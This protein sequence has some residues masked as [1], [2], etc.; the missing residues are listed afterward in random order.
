MFLDIDYHRFG[1]K[2]GDD[3]IEVFEASASDGLI[4]RDQSHMYDFIRAA[5]GYVLNVVCGG[6]AMYEQT[7]H[8]TDDQAEQVFAEGKRRLDDFAYRVAKGKFNGEQGVSPN[9]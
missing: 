5:G 9:A 4:L 7:V 3:S 2:S 1:A 8:L 6:I